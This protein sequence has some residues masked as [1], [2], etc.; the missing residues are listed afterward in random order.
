[1]RFFTIGLN[2]DVPVHDALQKIEGVLKKYDAE[3]PFEYEFP[4][5]DYARLFNA[6][7]RIG[8][9]TTIFSILAVFI[10]CIGFLA[11]P[12]LQPVSDG[13]K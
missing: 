10:S 13:K 6:E 4:D 9:L 8:K 1:M 5:D 2:P 11:W 3:A 7:E 12:H